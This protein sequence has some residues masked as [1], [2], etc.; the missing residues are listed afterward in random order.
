MIRF[1]S[2]WFQYSVAPEPMCE[3]NKREGEGEREKER[4]G[5]REGEREKE[6]LNET[7]RKKERWLRTGAENKKC[8]RI[9][10]HHLVVQIPSIDYMS[11]A[12]IKT[13]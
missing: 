4:G 6:D 2:C 10:N 1:I 3:E 5:E 11:L 13:S 9:T 7:E 12:A 8:V